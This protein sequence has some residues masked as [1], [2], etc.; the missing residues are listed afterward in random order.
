MT[1]PGDNGDP[2]SRGGKQ[3]LIPLNVLTI[4]HE[5]EAKLE[6]LFLKGDASEIDLRGF[7]FLFGEYD[8]LKDLLGQGEVNATVEALGTTRIR[9]T[10]LPGVWWISHE[11]EKQEVVGETLEITRH[12]ALLTTH[13]DD[14]QD[15][16]NDLRTNLAIL[17]PMA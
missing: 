5:I 9:E 4:L 12:P 11:N 1:A 7:P 8:M 16:L 15:G 13:T 6:A 17:K 14:V 10:R 3:Q 2:S